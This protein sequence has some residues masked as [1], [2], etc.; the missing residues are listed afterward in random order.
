M[1][2]IFEYL[3]N[4]STT[5]KKDVSEEVNK[6]RQ[7]IYNELS[8]PKY[9]LKFDTNSVE[10]AIKW[11]DTENIDRWKED[12]NQCFK[13]IKYDLNKDYIF[14]MSVWNNGS[15]EFTDNPKYSQGKIIYHK[16]NTDFRY[17]IIVI[18]NIC[19]LSSTQRRSYMSGKIIGKIYKFEI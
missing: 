8:K 7:K 2:N 19:Y 9:K 11:V 14:K 5:S 3:I 12:I 16:N 17:W 4:K 1:K 10:D 13:S 18:D 15:N 6:I